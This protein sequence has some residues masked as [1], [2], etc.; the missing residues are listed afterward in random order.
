METISEEDQLLINEK[1]EQLF[2]RI[3]FNK[4]N[5]KITIN[6]QDQIVAEGKSNRNLV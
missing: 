3:L 2:N 5:K 6:D 4:V 1:K